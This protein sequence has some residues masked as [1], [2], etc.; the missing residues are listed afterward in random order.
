MVASLRSALLIFA[1]FGATSV[2]PAVAGQSSEPLIPQKPAQVASVSIPEQL[3]SIGEEVAP[4]AQIPQTPDA[5]AP[6]A[7]TADETTP[8]SSAPGAA[9]DRNQDL[10]SLVAEL[11]SADPGNHEVE[12]LAAGIYFESKSEPLSGQLAVGQVIANRVKS[13]RFADSY[14]GVLFQP[15]QFSFVHGRSWRHI[16]PTDRQWQTAVAIAKIVDG[17][18]KGSVA[19]NAL[20]FHARRVHPAWHFQQVASIGNHLFFR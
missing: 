5:V 12:C 4:E 10:P 18:L 6:Q 2:A 8:Q 3:P 17:H 1:A 16:S 20:Y 13:H 19:G 9:I 14:C 15:G 7:S 11:R